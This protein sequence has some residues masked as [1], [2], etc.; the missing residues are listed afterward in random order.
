MALFP[1]VSV[2]P[3][4]I[5]R[6]F[7]LILFETTSNVSVEIMADIFSLGLVWSG[8]EIHVHGFFFFF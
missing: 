8:K 7:H 5:R 2:S 6:V 3:T 4:V 1:A